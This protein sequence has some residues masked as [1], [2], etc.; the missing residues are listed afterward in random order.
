MTLTNLR[1]IVTAELESEQC[2]TVCADKKRSVQRRQATGTG[3][4]LEHLVIK[5]DEAEEL[6]ETSHMQPQVMELLYGIHASKDDCAVQ[7]HDTH[8]RN[9]IQQPAGQVD[10]SLLASDLLRWTS[11]VVPLEFKLQDSEAPTAVGQLVNRVRL[12]LQ[13]QPQRMRV[14]GVAITM[15]SIEVF[16]FTKLRSGSFSLQRSGAQVQT[17]TYLLDHH[18]L[19]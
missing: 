18:V 4:S 7:I 13:Q 1:H 10:C 17:V 11:M 3:S 8:S 5:A 15:K 9:P 19:S 6:R 12:T 14:F 2:L 16:Q